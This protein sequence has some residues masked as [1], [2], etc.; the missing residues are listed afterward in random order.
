[1]K[2]CALQVRDRLKIGTNQRAGRA[3]GQQG[4]AGREE[5]RK[6]Q[7]NEATD[8]RTTLVRHDCVRTK[9]LGSNICM[10]AYRC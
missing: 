3:A 1:L 5:W 4:R 8:E 9:R 6:K 10:R 7:E 2:R